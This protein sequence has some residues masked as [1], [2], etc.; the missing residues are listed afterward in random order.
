MRWCVTAW[1]AFSPFLVTGC[2]DTSKPQE[3]NSLPPRSASVTEDANSQVPVERNAPPAS[4]EKEATD[5]QHLTQ[6]PLVDRI[7]DRLASQQLLEATLGKQL[8]GVALEQLAATQ[9][10]TFAERLAWGIFDG[11]SGRPEKANV[12]ATVR[13]VKLSSEVTTPDDVAA[14]LKHHADLV[15]AKVPEQHKTSVDALIRWRNS[16]T[17][18]QAAGIVFVLAMMDESELKTVNDSKAAIQDMFREIIVSNPDFFKAFSN[19]DESS[20]AY[21]S[22][23]QRTAKELLREQI[24]KASLVQVPAANSNATSDGPLS[25]EKEGWQQN[26]DAFA[27][28][29]FE[30]NDNLE[31]RPV[32]TPVSYDKQVDQMILGAKVEWQGEIISKFGRTILIVPF[33]KEGRI[34]TNYIGIVDGNYTRKIESLPLGTLVR[35]SMK[36]KKVTADYGGDGPGIHV[37]EAEDVQIVE[38]PME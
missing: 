5:N 6:L 32:G 22:E 26:A 19:A 25:K 1:L 24:D 23:E 33:G 3:G 31:K 17:N 13:L 20:A 27:R 10:L 14:F 21:R 30:D 7:A 36:L 12:T 37:W 29:Y 28:L 34:Y 16:F 2:R 9:E 18:S 38:L 8:Q 4:T 15:G 11:C 35:I